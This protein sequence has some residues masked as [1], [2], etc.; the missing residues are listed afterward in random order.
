MHRS[1]NEIQKKVATAFADW[2]IPTAKA[3]RN[4][5]N[6]S[7]EIIAIASGGLRNG[8]DVAKSIAL[9]A[10]LAGIARPFLEAAVRSSEEVL[11]A[12][13]II[14]EQLRVSMFCV[15]SKDIDELQRTRLLQR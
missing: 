6:A 2:G 8:V 15:G 12:V 3:L 5:R 13:Q 10:S 7:P 11:Q 4:A 9:G 1:E 14:E